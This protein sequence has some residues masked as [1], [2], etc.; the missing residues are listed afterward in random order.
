MDSQLEQ[1]IEFLTG[2]L[3]RM[4]V[5]QAGPLTYEYFNLLGQVARLVR[6]GAEPAT[7]RAKRRFIE[8]LSVH[9]GYQLAHAFSLYFQVVNFCEERA[10]T[11]RLQGTAEPSQSLRWLFRHLKEA[12]VPAE[13]M[14]A[15]LD[16]LEIEPVLTAHPTEAKRRAVLNQMLRLSA[17]A[18][19]PD[20]VFE[21]LWQTP[22]VRQRRPGPLHEVNNTL[23]FFERTIFETVARFYE[24]FDA[25]LARHYP[26]V[27]RS[28][29]FLT[30][31]SWVGGDR[32]G[33]PYVTPEVSLT[34]ARWHHEMAVGHYARECDRL[35][36]ELTHAA[37]GFHLTG[38]QVTES[39]DDREPFQP[40]EISRR[41]LVR[42]RR[43]L[44]ADQE[45]V[46]A[47][48]LELR[49][50]QADLRAQGAIRAASGRVSR[51]L[52]QAEAFGAH[53]AELDFR[54]HSSKL[55]AASEELLAE[56]QT[57]RRIQVQY[58]EAA[59]H[60]FIL[61]MTRSA[62]DLLAVLRLAHR[63]RLRAVDLVP[64]FETIEDL[65]R[66]PAI[67]R[68]LWADAD[69]RAHLEQRGG[70]QEVMLGYS[71]SNKDGGYLAANWFLYR[72]QKQ[73][74]AA[75]EEADVRLRFF[76]G[77]G[78]T[79]DR[80]GGASH[81]ALLAQPHA[82]PGGRIRITE[83]GEVVSLKYSQP[84][85]AQRNL[86]QLASAVIAANLVAPSAQETREL[87]RWEEAM[88]A[89]AAHSVRAYQDLVYGTP[90]FREYFW[91]ATPIDLVEHARLGSRPSRRAQNADLRQLRAIPW[92]F[93]WTQ[94]R[95]FLSAWYG[96]GQ[97]LDRW[98]TSGTGGLERLREMYQAWPVFRQLLDNAEVSLAKT[99]LQI[100]RAYA[101]L[102]ESPA[103]R[104]RIFGAI[105]AAYV[106][107]VE[108]VLR[109]TGEPRLLAKQ[110][111][112]AE[113]IRL[114]NPYVDPLNH[115][116]IRFLR[117]WR[118]AGEQ[119]RSEELRRLLALTVHGIA[120][121]MKST[122]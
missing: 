75:A 21:A 70:V 46:P 16:Q 102:V 84:L 40:D 5:E 85:I 35:I 49:G 36:E 109:V 73:I 67:L 54:D 57:L 63:A 104:D 78:G 122:G 9:E 120:F 27:K 66:A 91:H 112:L 86:E 10:R 83:Q 30:F 41:R 61:S 74:V 15:L 6:E 22:Q 117:D 93:A 92:V 25:E 17:Q 39:A 114:R 94:S 55:T 42:I 68:E 101:E 90:E 110:P 107:T 62:E 13:K 58:G 98:V 56:L 71:D 52:A 50:I 108:L 77:K 43:R 11:R 34:A 60:R 29:P 121:G 45:S 79:I 7:L 111:V 80:G 97:A 19:A 72:A 87:P 3:A 2:R 81:R 4:V 18:D 96:L 47:L 38:G 48:V 89:M 1:E 53:L 100:A 32:D 69:Y 23:F 82:A 31:A 37:P 105:E 118:A 14:Q 116:Q 33:H 59:A 26:G 12:R 44:R 103:V 51:L 64:L 24:R 20:E 76:H 113:S 88:Q 106:Q 8:R 115:L 95:H 28:R 99:D 119:R 65:D